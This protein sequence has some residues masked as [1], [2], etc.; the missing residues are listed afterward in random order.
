MVQLRVKTFSR[1]VLFPILLILPLLAACN[2]NGN[3]SAAVTELHN[4]DTYPGGDLLI[5]ATDLYARI[6]DPDL[7]IIDLGEIR[8]FREG[9]IPGAVHVWW[10]DTIEIHNEVYGMMADEE[11][12]DQIFSEAGLSSSQ[13]IVVYDDSGG[14]DAARFLWLLDAVGFDG[15]TFLLNGGRQA[16]E[17][18]GYS[19]T[20]DR[21]RPSAGG[22]EQEPNYEVLIGQGEV[23]S[24]I[25][26]PDT[27]IVDGRSRE[28]QRETWF[29]RLRHGQIPSSIHFPRDQTLQD[30]QVPY[31]KSAEELQDMLP[32]ELDPDT[33]QTVIAYGL[34]GVKGAH[35]WFTL[36]L[37]G[38]EN[39]RMYDGSWAEWGADPDLPI[40]DVE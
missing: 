11:T 32:D 37:L 33:D 30:G 8:S 23:Q 5:N 40:E 12:R 1:W 13:D 9:H 4:P 3:S 17:A 10:Q 6:D 2:T 19:L 26:D 25:D 27:V 36:K 15:N 38:F 22:L 16:W 21:Y 18:A 24:A 14:M 29:D 31:F 7:R 35:T 20:T 28:D 39:V 34:H